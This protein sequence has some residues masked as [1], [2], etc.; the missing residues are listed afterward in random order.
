MKAQ[1][2]TKKSLALN[3]ML[4][5][6]RDEREEKTGKIIFLMTMYGYSQGQQRAPTEEFLTNACDMLAQLNDATNL[7]F[8][9]ELKRRSL[10]N[11]PPSFRKRL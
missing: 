7:D 2:L 10:T 3:Q 6:Q 9:I 11:I 5:K 1:E 8:T 4:L